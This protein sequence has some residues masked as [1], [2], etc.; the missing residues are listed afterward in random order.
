MLYYFVLRYCMHVALPNGKY[1]YLQSAIML[2]NE[3]Q[4][5]QQINKSI[6]SQR[7]AF[8]IPKMWPLAWENLSSEVVYRCYYVLCYDLIFYDLYYAKLGVFIF[9]CFFRESTT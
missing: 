3:Q 4:R 8:T 7:F 1:L 9:H 6:P 2:T 5:D